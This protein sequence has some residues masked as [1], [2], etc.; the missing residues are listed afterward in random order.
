M[1]HGQDDQNPILWN[2][3]AS[4]G[5]NGNHTYRCVRTNEYFDARWI[6][7]FSHFSDDLSRYGYVYLMKH[8]SKTFEKFK[9]FQNKVENHH[10]RKIKFLRSDRGGLVPN[11]LVLYNSIV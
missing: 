6:S 5:L 2:N 8:K 10:N 1:P 9:E 7:L 3:G 4:N 11:V